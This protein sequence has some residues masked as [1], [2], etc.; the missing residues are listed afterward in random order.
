M[1]LPAVAHLWVGLR[2]HWV[3]RDSLALRRD[4]W[5]RRLHL[6]STR[7]LWIRDVPSLCALT[8][9]GCGDDW[10]RTRCFAAN[11]SPA[12]PRSRCRPSHERLLRSFKGVKWGLPQVIGVIR[13]FVAC[14]AGQ[15]VICCN[16]RSSKWSLPQSLWVKGNSSSLL[17]IFLHC[18]LTVCSFYGI[19][20]H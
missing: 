11:S 6:P 10:G 14:S 15:K 5:S 4:A 12:S 3:R 13:K 8:R 7:R 18:N 16:I 17:F 9:P 1:L 2:S 19:H 20:I